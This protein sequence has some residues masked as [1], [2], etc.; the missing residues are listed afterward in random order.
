MQPHDPTVQALAKRVAKLEAQNRRFTKAGMAALVAAS[1]VLVMGQAQTSR[2]LEANEF[3]LKD[4]SGGVRARLSMEA[5]NRPTLTFYRDKTHI[6]ASLAGGDEPFLTLSRAGTNEQ[7]QVGANRTFYGLGLYEEE[8]RAGLSVQNG[9]P[10]IELFDKS[11]KPRV[12]IE[13]GE[14]G[15]FI[16][17]GKGKESSMWSNSGFM[18][19]GKAG[20]S[21]SIDLDLADQSQSGFGMFGKTGSFRLDLGEEGPSLEIKDKEGYSTT[22][23][24]ADLVHPT[25]GR[26]ERTPAASLVLFGKDQKVL[27]SA[28]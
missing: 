28:P 1:A 2:V 11:G 9:N 22:L 16:L 21:F 19:S 25:S 6:S 12:A 23:G 4:K 14:T 26:K 15:E 10:G 7:V 8:I 3:V 18:I 27:W 17:L 24:R 13:S 5:M 20:S